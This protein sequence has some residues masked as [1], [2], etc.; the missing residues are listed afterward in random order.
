MH[1]PYR[2]QSPHRDFSAS[3][4]ELDGSIL[5]DT[6]FDEA[7]LHRL[8]TSLQDGTVRKRDLSLRG[9]Q[10][11]ADGAA[12]LADALRAN[13]SVTT[14]SLEWNTVGVHESSMQSLCDALEVNQTITS[15][16]LRNNSIRS[17][18]SEAMLVH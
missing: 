1:S 17:V 4:I 2:L 7:S 10:L 14:V 18:A 12:V 6:V 9:S 13:S 15:L 8:A 5:D 16:D 3:E 11:S